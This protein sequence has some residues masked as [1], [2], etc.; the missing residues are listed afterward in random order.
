M[1]LS[2]SPNPTAIL[3]LLN[4][5]IPSFL[6][7][8]LDIFETFFFS[9]CFPNKKYFSPSAFRKAEKRPLFF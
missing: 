8:F 7:T 1:L 4:R 5:T 9:I 2:A 3:F 6:K